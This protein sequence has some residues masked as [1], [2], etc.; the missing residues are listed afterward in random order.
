MPGFVAPGFVPDPHDFAG[1]R[2]DRTDRWGQDR[3]LMQVGHFTGFG[4]NLLEEDAAVQTS[5]GPILDRTKEHLASGDAAVADTRRVLLDALRAAESGELPPGSARSPQ[6][7]QLPN[8]VEAVLD[9]GQRWQDL[10]L[11]PV[12]GGADAELQ[13]RDLRARPRSV[14]PTS[15]AA[16]RCQTPEGPGP[17]WM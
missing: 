8:A 1:L 14:S 13:R 2:G 5:M 17:P 3:E 9:E 7:I 15:A 4:R 16:S 10:A 6:P 11:D 12:G